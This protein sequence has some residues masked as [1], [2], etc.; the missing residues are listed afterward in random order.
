[1]AAVAAPQSAPLVCV[2][3]GRAA[4]RRSSCEEL[5]ELFRDGHPVEA[6][7]P[8]PVRTLPLGEHP[9]LALLPGALTSPAL[10]LVGSPR[11]DGGTVVR[12]ARVRLTGDDG[13]CWVDESV[14]CIVFTF[15]H[16]RTASDLDV[17]LDL[18]HELTR[19]R[20]IHEGRDVWDRSF[21]YHRRP[22][23]IEGYAVAVAECRRL[24]LDEAAAFEHLSNPWMSAQ[25]VQELLHAVDAYLA[26]T[27]GRAPAHS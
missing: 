24:G 4:N 13:Y 17:Y 16:Y 3:I 23:E 18:M 8:R 22:T 9:F 5:T 14:P 19:I 6:G 26:T 2:A 7:Y 21:E 11:I 20:Q 27:S 15:A 12:G 25:Q 10:H 1:M